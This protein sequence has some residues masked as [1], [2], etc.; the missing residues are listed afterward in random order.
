MLSYPAATLRVTESGERR[1]LVPAIAAAAG[2][3]GLIVV[4][5][6]QARMCLMR[7]MAGLSRSPSLGWIVEGAEADPQP[8]ASVQSEVQYGLIYENSETQLSGL[9]DGVASELVLPLALSGTT[10]A[11]QALELE[12]QLGVWGLASKRQSS[13]ADLS[14]GQRQRL[15]LASMLLANN[16]VILHDGILGYIDPKARLRLLS[17]LKVHLLATGRVLLFFAAATD[18]LCQELM[19]FTVVAPTSHREADTE[20]VKV[21]T[22]SDRHVGALDSALISVRDLVWKPPNSSI[23]LFGSL[24]F[25]LFRGQ[26]ALVTGPNGSGKSSLGYL[27]A[28]IET[29]SSGAILV[30]GVCPSTGAGTRAPDVRVVPADPDCLLAE[31]TVS[32]E[33]IRS[34]QS[35]LGEADVDLLKR[36]LGIDSLD[37][38]SPFSLPWHQRRK[39]ALL[40]AM[41]SAELAIFLD[42]PT[43]EISDLD[44]DRLERAI[45]F[46]V[47]KGLIV[48]CASNDIRLMK[49][50]VFDV[51]IALPASTGT[52]DLSGPV[53]A[54]VELNP[55]ILRSLDKDHEVIAWE[56]AA[57]AWIA[58]AGEFCLFWTRFVYPTLTKLLNEHIAL[59]A[60]AS[61]LDLGCGTG[62]HTRAVRNL[63]ST[64]GCRITRTVGIDAID[65]FIQVARLNSA[66][67]EIFLRADLADEAIK[68]RLDV[69]MPE[70][71]ETVLVTAFFILHDLPSLAVISALLARLKRR[72]AIFLGVVV[73]PSFI[74]QASA[75]DEFPLYTLPLVAGERRDW[76][77]CGLFKVSSDSEN[78]LVVPYFHRSTQQY[79]DVLRS[80]WGPVSIHHSEAAK[81]AANRGDACRDDEILFLVSRAE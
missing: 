29:P 74:E 21:S 33:L 14:D 9:F 7:H 70:S 69:L 34:A 8:V 6:D 37:D 72:G 23:S 27:L 11:Q 54:A 60:T 47:V 44:V 45:E 76:D 38:R 30:S 64:A 4:S 28:G 67:S 58:N 1:V 16:D 36:L 57:N 63:L 73:S 52:V 46:C 41:I 10:R 42:E 35:T 66:E 68:S 5:D 32:E 56:A 55:R 81:R 2:Q 40:Q 80:A 20:I 65:R 15:L 31:E 48:I 18:A 26:A 78:S 43:A 19:D 13:L 59:P 79:V 25:S 53:P 22:R 51:T 75:R 3:M 61:L 77:S 12:Y 49:S 17:Y 50:K 71:D 62:L 39:V 24:S